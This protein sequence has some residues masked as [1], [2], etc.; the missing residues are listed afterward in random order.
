MKKTILAEARWE[1]KWHRW[2][3]NAS[4]QGQRRSFY[5]STPGR[6]GKKEAEEKAQRWAD[7]RSGSDLRFDVAVELW[8][9]NKKLRITPDTYADQSCFIRK[10][11]LRPDLATRRISKITPALYQS[12]LDV[13][14]AQGLS[15]CTVKELRKQ[16]FSFLRFARRS[17][18][19]LADVDSEDIAIPSAMPP[20]SEKPILQPDDLRTLF[21]VGTTRIRHQLQPCWHINAFRLAAVL[22]LRRGE[23]VALR[24]QHITDDALHIVSSINAHGSET[25]GKTKNAVR[26]IALSDH[27]RAILSAQRALLN[28]HHIVSPFVFPAPSGRHECPAQLSDSWRRYAASNGIDP[29]VTLHC[30]RHTAI[31]I[32]KADVPE[33]LLK[34]VV[35]HSRSMDTFG[36]YGHAVSDD[37]LRA[38]KLMEDA[39]SRYL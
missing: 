32:Y 35:G 22:G 12:I 6:K 29:A 1:E 30:L 4:V 28:Q 36:Q 7:I 39:L 37:A 5:S 23:L 19:P 27:T 24:W 3:I 31:S 15:R 2:K 18:F 21:T 38:S 14:A 10:W 9:E 34:Q 11:F 20:A 17:H 16:L 25:H 13:P 26:V 8:L 33:Q